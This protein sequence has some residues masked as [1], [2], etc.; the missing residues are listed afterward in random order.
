MAWRDL[1]AIVSAADASEEERK[2]ADDA[3][4]EFE[5]LQ[6]QLASATRQREEE[7]KSWAERFAAQEAEMAKR[8]ERLAAAGEELV[9]RFLCKVIITSL[10]HI[11]S[12]E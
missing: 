8:L 5:E 12:N 6:L 1:A 11:H 10:S 4:E 2:E 9:I 7:S 3:R